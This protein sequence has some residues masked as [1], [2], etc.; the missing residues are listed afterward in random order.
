[1]MSPQENISRKL[2]QDKIFKIFI[3]I[4]FVNL[5][6]WFFL[7]ISAAGHIQESYVRQF[8]NFIPYSVFSWLEVIY[9]FGGHLILARIV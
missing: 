2:T 1:M 7:A 5:A 8:K 9:M 3:S 4:H 6:I